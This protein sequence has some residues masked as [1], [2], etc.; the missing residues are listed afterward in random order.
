MKIIAGHYKG[1]VLKTVRDLSVRPTASRVKQTVF[2]ILSN[3]IDFNGARVLDLFAGSGSLGLEALSRGAAVVTF[4]ENSKK[5]LALLETNVRSIGVESKC[6][7]HPADV[8][9]FLKNSSSSFDLV[10]CDP[11]YKLETI[12]QLPNTIY[13]SSVSRD[14]TYVVM[15]HHQKSNIELSDTNYEILRKS[16]G[17]TT[18]LVLKTHKPLMT[19]A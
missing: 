10:F 6:T 12:G 7:F 17:Q 4:V 19:A 11:P 5:V 15:E 2:D 1:R 9:W 13:D 14:G 8:F 16:F 3:R 18:L